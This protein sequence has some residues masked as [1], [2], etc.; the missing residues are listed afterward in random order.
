MENEDYK[1]FK[2][3]DLIHRVKET[4]LLENLKSEYQPDCIVVFG[5]AVR[6]EDTEDSDIDL[7]LQAKAKEIN[8]NEFEEN[9]SRSIQLHIS[10]SVEEYSEELRNNIANGTVLHGYLEIF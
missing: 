8:L 9:L 2:K 10:K 6:G 4:G 3:I 7:F 1:H 5:S